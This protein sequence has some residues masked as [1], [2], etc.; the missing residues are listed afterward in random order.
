MELGG[1]DCSFEYPN[2]NYHDFVFR[3]QYDGSI[4]TQSPV[5]VFNCDYFGAYGI[6]HAPIGY[7][8]YS[9][10]AKL[11]KKYNNP[12]ALNE[13]TIKIDVDNWKNYSDVWQRRFGKKLYTS[14]QEM[15][16]EQNM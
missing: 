8:F 3:A 7:A 14:Y 13:S 15:I 10:Q 12:N 9:D 6:D 1:L 5:V 2:F 16:N 4:I 11:A